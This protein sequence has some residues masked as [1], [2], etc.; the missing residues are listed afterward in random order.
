MPQIA[1]ALGRSPGTVSRGV[2]RGSIMRRKQKRQSY[3]AS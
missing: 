2:S 3:R 1:R